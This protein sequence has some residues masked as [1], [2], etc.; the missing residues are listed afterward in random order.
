MCLVVWVLGGEGA[1]WRRLGPTPGT[2]ETK[3][4]AGLS[5]LC[6][7]P[8]IGEVSGFLFRSPQKES[9]VLHSNPGWF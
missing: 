8:A 4:W 9:D 7:S 2:L 3:V 5:G 1:C 6:R